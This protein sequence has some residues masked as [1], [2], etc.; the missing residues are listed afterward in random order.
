[1]VHNVIAIIE[2]EKVLNVVN[3]VI[4]EGMVHS[5]ASRVNKDVLRP[6]AEHHGEGGDEVG[7]DKSESGGCRVDAI[8]V[9][10]RSEPEHIGK[11]SLHCH[12]VTLG[13]NCII[14]QF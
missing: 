11:S 9:V 13:L 3:A 2:G 5:G 12:I 6:V 4:C 14:R 8:Q 7:Q 10:D 1:M